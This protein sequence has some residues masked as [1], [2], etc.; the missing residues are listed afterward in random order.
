MSPQNAKEA[1]SVDD[2]AVNEAKRLEIQDKAPMVAAEVLFDGNIIRQITAHRK[3][4]LRV[5][6]IRAGMWDH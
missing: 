2:K 1:G 6:F 3:V 4:F 5:S